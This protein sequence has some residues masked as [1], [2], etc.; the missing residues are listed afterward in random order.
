MGILRES[1]RHDLN[2]IDISTREPPNQRLLAL[3]GSCGHVADQTL[4]RPS[5]PL[6][7][8]SPS[9]PQHEHRGCIK[10]SYLGKQDWG[11]TEREFR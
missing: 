7:L 4:N 6:V 3:S 9:V 11:C 1:Q 10:A 2:V 5:C 8:L